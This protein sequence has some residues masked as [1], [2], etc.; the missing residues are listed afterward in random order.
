M[1]D[2]AKEILQVNLEDEMRQSYL[3]YAM[4][5]I[6]G[7]ALPD[8]RDGLKPV[9]RRALFAMSEL[10]NDWNKPYKKSARVVGD[11]FVKGTLVHTETGLMPVEEIAPGCQVQLSDGRLSSVVQCFA[12]PPSAVIRVKLSNGYTFTVTPGQLFRV[13]RDDLTIAWEKAE[14]LAGQRVL[15]TSS[16]ALVNPVDHHDMDKVRL[17]YIV[18]LLVAEGY[19]TDRGRSKR[20]AV[21]MVDREPLEFLYE[22]CVE[23]GLSVSWREV[24]PAKAHYQPQHCVRLNGLAEAYEACQ[25][26]S[27]YKTVS[28]WILADRGFFAPFLAGFTD[29]DG[30]IS[31]IGERASKREVV[32]VSTSEQLLIQIQAMLADSGIHAC[33]T[34]EDFSTRAYG[35]GHLTRYH[36]WITGDHASRFGD[37][38]YPH[39]KISRKRNSALQLVEW[40]GRVLNTT[41]EC[42]PGRK[43]FEALSEHHLGGGW[44]QDQNGKKFRAG[45]KYPSG[46]K[47][48]Y[49]IDLHERDISFRQL[50]EWGVVAK[51][52]RI[53]SPLAA[54]LCN[55]I[56]NYAV[57]SVE[58]VL[59]LDEI[60]ETFDV[61]IADENHE[62][63]V[64]G[65]AVHNCIGKYHPHGDTA[66]YDTIV[67]MAQ[68][69]SLRYMLV[70]GQ[71]N[72]GCFTGD[73]KIELVDGSQKSFAELA[74]L[75]QHE[76]F[77]VYAVD[78]RGHI[79]I[80][81]GHSSRVTRQNA[82]L[83]EIV[84]DNGEVIRC[85]PNHLF[86]LRDGTYKEADELT[87]EDSLMP[88]VFDTAP[89][90]EGL[91]DYLRV[92]QPNLGEYQFVHHL[93]DQFNVRNGLA[94]PFNGPF[95]R[96][97]IN[98]DRWDNSPSNIQR[99]TFLE[100][101][102]LHSLQIK[103]LWNDPAFREAQ[104]KGVERYY[105]ENPDASETRRQRFIKQN[106][107]QT[108]RQQ[109]GPR[110][111][112]KLRELYAENPQMGEMISER[113][114]ALWQDQDYRE[115]MSEALTGIEKKPLS[116]ENKM[117]VAQIISEKS[118]IMWSDPVKRVEITEAIC[119]ALASESVRAKIS[120]RVKQNWQDPNYR[121]KFHAE[122]FSRM[123]K[124][125]WQK[126]E[127][128]IL[129]HDKIEQQWQDAG[130]REAQRHGVQKSNAQRLQKNPQMMQE[131]NHKAVTVLRE[132]W[133]KPDYRKQVMRQKIAGYVQSLIKI[134][135][136][137]EITPAVYESQR[138]A[139]WIPHLPKALEYFSSFEA[140]LEAGRNY[141][142]RIV[143]KYTLGETA[144]V[145]DIT[146]DE[147][148]NFLL[149]CGVFVHNSI[150]GDSPAAMRYTEVRMSRIAHE[151]LADLDKETVDFIP[152]YDESEHEPTVFPTRLPNLLVNGSSGI[153]VGM[154]TNIPPHNL[155]E[156]VNACIA[157]IDEP[158]LSISALMQHIPGPDFPTAALI[159]GNRGIREAYETGRGRV[160]MRAKTAIETDEIR[161]RQ[162][163]IVTELP[164]QVNKARLIEKIAELVKEKKLEGIAELRDESDKDGLRIYIE[165]RRGESGEV[166]LNNLF[167][168]TAL[169]C[170]FGVNMVALVE[171]QPRLLNLKQVLEAFLAHRR[172]VVVRRTLFDLRKARDRAHIVEGL[173]VA[174]VNLE[175]LIVLI[176][177]AADP[178]AAKAG[179]LERVWMPGVI[180]DWLA[181]TGA[182]TARPENLPAEFGLSAAGYR[183][184]PVQAQ[185][186]LDLR[187]HRLT[188]LEQ[189]K[190]LD[191][192][193]ELLGRIVDYLEI[194]T[195]P[196]RLTAVIRAELQE[197]HSSYNDPRRTVILPDEQNLNLEDLINEET[198]VVTLSHAGYVKAQPLSLYRAQRRGGRGRA[199]TTVK[200][201]D[202]VDKLFVA[203][204]HDTVLCFSNRGR[205]Y[206]KKVYELP[207]AGRTARGRPIVNLLPLEEGERINAVLAV[208]EFADDHFVFF[209]TANGTVKKTPLSEYS[210]PRPSGIIAIDLRD[211]DQLVNVELTNG[212]CDIILFT[213]AGKAQRFAETEVRDTGRS[214]CGVRGI[215]LGEGQKVIALIVVGGG[216]VLAV[217]EN[218]YGKRTAV[219]EYP[220]HARGGKGVIAI[221]TNERNGQVIGAVQVENDHEIMLIT[222]GGTLVRTP[223]EGISLVGRNTQG[224]TLI[225]LQ[226]GEKLVGI[227]KIES[228][229]ETEAGDDSFVEDD[230]LAPN[231]NDDEEAA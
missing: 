201:E 168:H 166:V 13:L 185:A 128:L 78:D 73:T 229:G 31:D 63:L 97:H 33:L 94:R 70:D 182:D 28:R 115:K 195:V 117:R 100:H 108:F 146:V 216:T 131:I 102:H 50:E 150:D 121:A 39:L 132:N 57:L 34:D 210:R 120:E 15:A 37:L 169:Q 190:L 231:E 35:E 214:A 183:L 217:T 65:C 119:C 203:S 72:F 179:L 223:V 145:Y 127:T 86:M 180:A 156:V 130:F 10:G 212:Q 48:R 88:G 36:L 171:G 90:R 51:L 32:L 21:N 226:G 116:P 113:M 23:R 55:L 123:A 129:H 106:Q 202:F 56:N 25:T 5:V 153:A 44:Y 151:L 147:H 143:A 99:L 138:S 61:Q 27:P 71:G 20:V 189:R 174:L 74:Q 186:I 18:G 109:N 163:I 175:P 122:H 2:I 4:S 184:S 219:A 124:V 77:H 158:G 45:I 200:E 107:D 96:H 213:D 52:D 215:R 49:D 29:G 19:L 181:R 211:G 170:V 199:A 141:N 60:A 157:L 64:Q 191:E 178:A 75:P 139:Q 173:A 209:A 144:D 133:Q 188:G 66:V 125:L 1:T 47:I 110:V 197:L 24:A 79:V 136:N 148:H 41:S 172:E 6:V 7:R 62:F 101:L 42:I 26:T 228:I 111:A 164:Y 221:R 85:T 176:R 218:G 82:E 112:K 30:Y 67:R 224:V 230:D 95:V 220:R 14:N 159:N 135:P 91:N 69:F 83:L 103:E 81:E 12:N 87:D 207:Q 43:I 126:P 205:V 187:L 206:W 9:H 114:Q 152:N 222:D 204:T 11:C 160:Q 149:T 154:A 8:V 38:I 54:S 208:R 192:Y 193:Q 92:F 84:L 167:Q 155:G 194:L 17:A 22:F 58:D 68:P 137:Q 118:R 59:N 227:E 16:R 165:L 161:N 98:F 53:G 93:A 104:K 140:M 162:A 177:T 225:R 46:R 40:A 80:A 76:V 196:E 89:V 3:D 198:M 134:F 105:Q 142:H